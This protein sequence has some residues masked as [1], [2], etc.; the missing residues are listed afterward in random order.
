M[1]RANY[2][3]VKCGG[4][5]T[6]AHHIIPLNGSTRH[7]SCLNHQENLMAL[8]HGCHTETRRIRPK[9]VLITAG[10]PLFDMEPY[11]VPAK[12]VGDEPEREL[13]CGNG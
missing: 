4:K 7:G 6:E 12:P 2:I 11:A 13:F 9:K 3:C 1:Q 8:C 5:A 10:A